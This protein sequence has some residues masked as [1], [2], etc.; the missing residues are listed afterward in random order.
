M[1]RAWIASRCFALAPCADIVARVAADRCEYGTATRLRD[2]PESFIVL[3]AMCTGAWAKVPVNDN[4]LT[5]ASLSIQERLPLFCSFRCYLLTMRIRYL[6]GNADRRHLFRL[7][8]NNLAL[9]AEWFLLQHR[10]LPFYYCS[11]R[12]FA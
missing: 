11:N 10:A 1:A 4:E 8:R 2:N 5:L 9:Y 3:K 7:P 6:W 12:G